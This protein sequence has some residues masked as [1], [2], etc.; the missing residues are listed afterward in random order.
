MNGDI[1]LGAELIRD[2]LGLVSDRYRSVILEDTYTDYLPSLNL[3][4]QVN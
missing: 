2:D 1:E 3:I 4:F